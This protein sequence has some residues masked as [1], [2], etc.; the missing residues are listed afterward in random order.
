MGGGGSSYKEG[1][2]VLMQVKRS[3]KI[4]GHIHFPVNYAYS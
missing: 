3:Q 1:S 2:I 4:L